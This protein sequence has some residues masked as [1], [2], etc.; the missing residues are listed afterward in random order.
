VFR[1]SLAALGGRRF[2]GR[3]HTLSL[4]AVEQKGP[5]DSGEARQS[6][7]KWFE[8]QKR[9]GLS[10]FGRS[11]RAGRTFVR[12]ETAQPVSRVKISRPLS[13]KCRVAL[14]RLPCVARSLPRW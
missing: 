12:D 2:C 10:A 1:T 5:G 6:P 14:L 13:L 11:K 8:G 9:S 4:V 3:A 7:F